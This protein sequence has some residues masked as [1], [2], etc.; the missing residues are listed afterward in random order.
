[1]GVD[2]I[3]GAFIFGLTVPRGSHLFH[4]CNERIEEFVLT[5][6]LPLYF[7]LSGLKTDVTTIRT[8]EEGAI[9]LLVIFC[10]I[11]G[12]FVGTGSAAYFSGMPLRESSVVA[13][14]MNTRGLVELIVLNL[15]MQ[16]KILSVRTFS[17]M[18]IMCLT[19]TFMTCPLV[20]LIYPPHLRVRAGGL[21]TKGDEEVVGSQ[22]H[23]QEIEMIIAQGN[24]DA[25][26]ESASS[27]VQ[28]VHDRMMLIVDAVYDM[29]SLMDTLSF[30]V[31]YSNQSSLVMTLMHFVEPTNS[32]LDQY[33]PL[34]E[35]DKVVHIEEEV[36]DF[37]AAWQMSLDYPTSRKSELLPLSLFCKAMQVGVS[38][39][40]VQGD[41][42]EFSG[43]MSRMAAANDA[44]V[45]L[46]PYRSDGG[47]Y[48]QKFFWSTVFS[49]RHLPVAL[50]VPIDSL[51]S[52]FKDLSAQNS[53][54]NGS[55]HN[56]SRSN[57]RAN[58][59]TTTPAASSKDQLHTILR[60]IPGVRQHSL[61]DMF[62]PDADGEEIPQLYTTMP[63]ESLP[64]HR[65]NT[66]THTLPPKLEVLDRNA[67][68]IVV[69]LITGH[70]M[71]ATVLALL[72][73]IA[74]S[75]L[76]DVTLV[77]VKDH[78]EVFSE[79][80]SLALKYFI[81]K[82]AESKN[83]CVHY[84]TFVSTEHN[85]LADYC[86]SMNYA[87]IITACVNTS[88]SELNNAID[89]SQCKE[90]GSVGSAVFKATLVHRRHAQ[91]IVVHDYAGGRHKRQ[92]SVHSVVTVSTDTENHPV[93]AVVATEQV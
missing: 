78:E 13:V 49:D 76:H 48:W 80:L 23:A 90:F 92:M 93:D 57:S 25:D 59:L 41:P 40:H 62:D 5:I 24:K 66:V 33:L 27:M 1:M 63:T 19:T 29:Q 15:G 17:V 85:E 32:K 83:V 22:K 21:I 58:Q 46:F 44:S 26:S 42:E 55:V 72:L 52:P 89:V 9:T 14:L 6:M 37:R 12:K 4:E 3:F 74:T 31:P 82:T 10:A 81:A 71:D 77:V 7:T 84:S 69:G 87:L 70:R 34:N 61:I 73:K 79:S 43:A 67:S 30:F 88:A 51:H 54:S 35:E 86:E 65:R 91:M 50:I 28:T 45:V 20:E 75:P 68:S 60:G 64:R 8:G 47:L 36:T 18:V 53:V 11:A 2:A 38:A 39:F 16:S 56:R